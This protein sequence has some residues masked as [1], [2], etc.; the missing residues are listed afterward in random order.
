MSPSPWRLPAKAF[1]NPAK[2]SGWRVGYCCEP[3]CEH[4]TRLPWEKRA[5]HQLLLELVSHKTVAEQLLRLPIRS[6]SFNHR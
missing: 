5:G 4:A 2:A 1:L 3:G 6:E